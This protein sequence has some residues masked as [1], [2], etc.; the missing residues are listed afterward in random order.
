MGW[1]NNKMT[2]RVRAITEYLVEQKLNDL[3]SDLILS[4]VEVDDLPI[5]DYDLK[6]EL[7]GIERYIPK[8]Q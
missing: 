3:A 4:N 6:K 2:T 5:S 1:R 8:D 7:Q